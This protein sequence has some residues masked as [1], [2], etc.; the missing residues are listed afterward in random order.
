MLDSTGPSSTMDR[1]ADSPLLCITV[2][3]WVT[4][5]LIRHGSNST[6]GSILHAFVITARCTDTSAA[7]LSGARFGPLEI[8]HF[9]TD[10]ILSNKSSKD[11]R[12]AAPCVLEV[13]GCCATVEVEL[14]TTTHER[15]RGV[16]VVCA[17]Q[18]YQHSK[19]CA[20]HRLDEAPQL[21]G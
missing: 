15:E 21:F 14:Q 10:A 7:T 5:P 2:L 9:G 17:K 3:R 13:D 8:F 16:M 18:N 12:R 19:S 11:I 20:C 1:K 6:H 4:R